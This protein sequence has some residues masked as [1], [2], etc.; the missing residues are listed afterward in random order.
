MARGKS[1]SQRERERERERLLCHEQNFVLAFQKEKESRPRD[2]VS[3]ADD[4]CEGRFVPRRC[5]PREI[6]V[7]REEKVRVGVRGDGECHKL[8][9]IMGLWENVTMRLIGRLAPW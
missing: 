4:F 8:R 9:A 6:H 3:Y 1:K 5:R 2:L 7:G